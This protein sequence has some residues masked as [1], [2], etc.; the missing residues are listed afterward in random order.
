MDG[1]AQDRRRA[2]LTWMDLERISNGARV[3]VEYVPI[4]LGI[5][6]AFAGG[7]ILWDAWGPE[8]VGPMRDRRR[9]VRAAIDPLGEKLVGIGTVMLGAA[10]IGREWRWE[11][12]TVLVGTLLVLW[13][14][15][16]NRRYIRETLF[17]RGAARRGLEKPEEKPRRMRIR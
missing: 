17:F 5:L 12:L 3:R 11:T 16:R 10:L 7:A 14:G 1:C 13:G 9:R 15:V 6:V 2:V 4:V 8:W